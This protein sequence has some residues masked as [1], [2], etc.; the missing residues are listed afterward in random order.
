MKPFFIKSNS[1]GLWTIW[2][3]SP[4]SSINQPLFLQKTTYVNLYTQITN[5]YLELGFEF[6]NGTQRIGDLAIMCP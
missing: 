6:E 1:F 4:L 3:D 2:A 5:I